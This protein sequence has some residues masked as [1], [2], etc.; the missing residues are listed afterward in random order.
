MY[1]PLIFRLLVNIFF[2]L[3]LSLLSQDLVINEFMASN[4]TTVADE[5]GEFDDWVEIYNYGTTDI[6]MAGLYL[7]DDLSEPDL[8]QIPYG[9]AETII[10]AGGY[11]LFWFDKDLTQGALHVNAKLS[12]GGEQIGLY[13]FNLNPIDTLTYGNQAEDIS[14]GRIS[15]NH[16]EWTFFSVPT[17]NAPNTSNL[18]PADAPLFSQTTASMGPFSLS[19]WS[20][21][22]GVNIYYTTDGSVPTEASQ[23]YVAPILVDSSMT[24]RA[25]AMG[26]GL[27]KS[28]VA[29]NMYLINVSHHFPVVFA[30][31]DPFDFYDPTT[32]IYVNYQE[33]WERPAQVAL[34][35]QDGSLAFDQPA[36]VEIQGS[37]S[38]EYPHKSLAFK[39]KKYN[40]EKLFDYPIFQDLPFDKY[41]SFIIRNSG[42]DWDKLYFRDAFVSSLVG[43]LSDV[44]DI[45][46]KPNLLLQ[47]YRPA[48]GYFNGE[49]RG[50]YNIRERLDKRYF[51]THFGLSTSEYDFIKNVDKVKVG[52]I[53]KWYEFMDFIATENMN[54]PA[55][56]DSLSQIMDVES[57]MD[58]V[59]LNVYINN[60]DWPGNN[61]RRYRDYSADGKWRWL[62]YDLDFTYSL[63]N[64]GGLWNSGGFYDNALSR[65][66]V[67]Q[68]W[69]W[70]NPEWSTRPFRALV[71]NDSWRT[72]F[73]N[74]TADQLNILF[75]AN[76]QQNRLDRFVDD[77][78]PEVQQ[79]QC[80]WQ[81]CF[82]DWEADLAKVEN[83]IHGRTDVVRTHYVQR[84]DE[85]TG[86]TDVTISAS[87][88]N[89]GRVEWSTL[90]LEEDHFPWSGIYFSGVDIPVK[91]V[92]A[93]GY[94]FVGWSDPFLGSDSV[95]TVKLFGGYYNLVANFQPINNNSC[96]PLAGF[97][98]LGEFNG[99]SYYLSENQMTWV[100]AQAMAA[101][102][103]GDMLSIGSQ[104]E[105][106]FIQSNISEVVFMGLNDAILETEL[107]WES[108]EALGYTNYANCSWCAVNTDDNDFGVLQHWDGKWGL[109]NQWV[110]RRFIL[111]TSCNGA[112][113]CPTELA[114]FAYM[115]AFENHHYFLSIYPL[116]WETAKLQAEHEGGYLATINSEAENTFVKENIGNDMV[117]IGYHDTN[118]E[119]L[120][121]WANNEA[122]T[123][124]KSYANN[125]DRDYGLINFWAGTWQMVPGSLVRNY[126]VEMDC[127]SG[128]APTPL[129]V[130]QMSVLGVQGVRLMSI[131]PIP[132]DDFITARILSEK[133]EEIQL[134]IVN[135][136]G[137]TVQTL[138]KLLDGGG[139]EIEFEIHELPAGI[140]AIQITGRPMVQSLRFVKLQ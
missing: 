33:N 25:I 16:V 140:Y 109:N 10:P 41:G 38:A 9:S 20:V 30:A 93:P 138:R 65:L 102:L 35:E 71:Q 110:H 21:Q 23:L 119:G 81:E 106:D 58:Y 86:L 87:P 55:N 32:G 39:A 76:R 74:R 114:D 105:N 88:V 48:I 47:A 44:G 79:H 3:P 57:Y 13:D 78:A 75:D 27:G 12:G 72:Q 92:A 132:A 15:D 125:A 136:Q 135:A 46:Q 111:E 28:K 100:E 99:H 31:F 7:T 19:L 137:E 62:V 49:Y 64:E 54:L 85:I 127:A 122:V 26:G 67:D 68:G 1:N 34:F 2:L 128:T 90:H 37:A 63:Y 24:V 89:G 123:I 139:N 51:K 94:E 70:P 4:G 14:K 118:Q 40:N 130:G 121:Q 126:V 59:I 131:Y 133:E 107:E 43:D 115:G 83:F 96:G 17:P 56:F 80:K 29:T 108:G 98:Q 22:P 36:E 5:N 120:G 95:T 124:D 50:I 91:A 112:G 116:D 77:Y 66:Y 82:D 103:E 97:V 53:D 42:Q 134:S 11:K 52:T 84:Y 73:I 129:L 61:N 113:A 117:F 69:N 8:W 45:I 60:H 6:D 101:G 104:A 18:P